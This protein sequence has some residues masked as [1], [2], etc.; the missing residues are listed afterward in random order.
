M[1]TNKE[2]EKWNAIAI[3][4]RNVWIAIAHVC[5]LDEMP[6]IHFQYGRPCILSGSDGLLHCIVVVILIVNE[7]EYSFWVNFYG[8][9]LPIPHRTR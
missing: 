8:T 2:R 7:Q 4:L 9:R 6:K 1:G 3:G 5:T